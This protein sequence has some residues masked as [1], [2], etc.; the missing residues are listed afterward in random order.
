MIL[1]GLQIFAA[2]CALDA[3]IGAVMIECFVSFSVRT[4][5]DT[6][7]GVRTYVCTYVPSPC[8]PVLL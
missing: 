5:H 1:H 3:G 2:H 7:H 6:K 8:L 4:V